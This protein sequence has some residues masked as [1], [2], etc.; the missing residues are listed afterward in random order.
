M[1]RSSTRTL[2]TTLVVLLVAA[3][4]W[5]ATEVTVTKSSTKYATALEYDGTLYRYTYV[6]EVNDGYYLYYYLYDYTVPGVVEY[7]YGMIDEGDVSWTASGLSLD[8]NTEDIAII[9]AGGDLMLEW[10]FAPD[11][12]T[13]RSSKT[14]I[15]NANTKQIVFD[16]L[17]SASAV[18][19][20][21]FLGDDF[22]GTGTIQ[23]RKGK[24]ILQVK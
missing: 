13:E 18:A 14:T 20:G 15:E 19:E 1:I 3:A 4:V 12:G 8:T 11:G 24:V 2:V 17:E 6:N 7:G 10:S 23:V 21:S 5:A 9:G 16:D 22:A